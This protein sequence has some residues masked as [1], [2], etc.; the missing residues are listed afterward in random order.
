M[1]K[2]T[3]PANAQAMPENLSTRRTALS[4]IAD[5]A[6][7][8]ARGP[9]ASSPV[10]VAPASPVSALI[11]RHKAANEAFVNTCDFFHLTKQDDEFSARYIRCDHAEKAA[12]TALCEYRPM[13]FEEARERGDYLA[14]L[15]VHY[16]TTPKQVLESLMSFVTR[17]DGETPA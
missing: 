5:A 8:L 13:T 17:R 9:L 1:P 6:S 7:A 10:D 11:A 12:M 14:A 2:R 4:A 15:V 16:R 3:L